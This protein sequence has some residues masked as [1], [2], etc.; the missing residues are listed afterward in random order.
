[1]P[2]REEMSDWLGDLRWQGYPHLEPVRDVASPQALDAPAEHRPRKAA[3][4]RVETLARDNEALRAKLDGMARLAAEFERRLAET[5]SS[6]EDAALESDSARRTLELERA[7]LA[8]ELEAARSELCRRETR[9]AARDTEL[10]RE[11]DRRAESEKSALE[12]HRR[13]NDLNAELEAARAKASELAG[14]MTELRRQ[15]D[16]SNER[17]LQAK[18]LTD[19]DI[20]LLRQEMREFLAKFHRIQESFGEKS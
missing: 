2:P 1:M 11:R 9:E 14:A 19:Q 3:D 5:A 7:K 8:G 15:A 12:A 16:A 17:L 13:L 18:A 4:A 20:H 10:S 6:Y